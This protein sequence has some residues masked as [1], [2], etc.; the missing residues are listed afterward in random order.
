MSDI[1]G[2]LNNSQ[3]IAADFELWINLNYLTSLRTIISSQV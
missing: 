2:Y 1:F 3:Y